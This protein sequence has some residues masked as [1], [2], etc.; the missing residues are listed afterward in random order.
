ML[1]GTYA[2]DASALE[3]PYGQADEYSN[4][5]TF[6]FR[7]QLRT[8]CALKTM[9]ATPHAAAAARKRRHTRS[10]STAVPTITTFDGFARNA[11]P[12]RSPTTAPRRALPSTRDAD[13]T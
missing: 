9:A 2:T 5:V 8:S 6:P 3:L 1:L 11:A 7:R 4:F 12:A 13:A 10:A